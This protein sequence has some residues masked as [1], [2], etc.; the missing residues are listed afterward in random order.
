VNLCIH[1][2]YDTL[3][4]AKYCLN[5]A[6]TPVVEAGV[7]IDIKSTFIVKKCIHVV[8]RRLFIP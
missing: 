6:F 3:Q 2:C 4:T 5:M 1:P 8:D 7:E